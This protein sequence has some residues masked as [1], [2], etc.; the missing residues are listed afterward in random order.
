[1]LE[2]ISE[3]SP[4]LDV[5]RSRLDAFG[6]PGWPGEASWSAIRSRA[7]WTR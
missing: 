5:C 6:L 3:I 7:Q 4:P 2:Q 1:M